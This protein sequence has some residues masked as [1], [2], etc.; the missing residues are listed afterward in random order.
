MET[1]IETSSL[2][3]ADTDSS[4]HAS[5]G[6]ILRRLA[7]AFLSDATRQATQEQEHLAL[8]EKL[9]ENVEHLGHGVYRF[10]AGQAGEAWSHKCTFGDTL[11]AFR[12]ANPALRITAICPERFWGGGSGGVGVRHFIVTT[13]PRNE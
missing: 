13:E 9:L 10:E 5:G 4:V 8:A 11:A 12:E 3:S 6:G 7:R 2:A 1:R